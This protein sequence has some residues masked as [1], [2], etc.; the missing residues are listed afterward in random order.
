MSPP[1]FILRAMRIWE[2]I[3]ETLE[4]IG[5]LLVIAIAYVIVFIW[6]VPMAI[7]GDDPFS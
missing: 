2:R 3:W 4:W 7:T 1:W 5:V 6:L